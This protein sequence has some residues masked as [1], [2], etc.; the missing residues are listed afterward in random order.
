MKTLKDKR[1]FFVFLFLLSVLATMLGVFFT[2][3]RYS[4][5]ISSDSGIYGGDFEYI[6]AEK[7]E[8]ESVEELIAAVE[9]GYSNITIADSVEDP[10]IITS[11][12]T[13]V[14][15]DLIL[16]LNGHEIQRNNHNPMLNIT[17]GVRMTVIDSSSAQTGSFYNP[18]GSVLEISG[19]TLTV[20]GGDFV[21]G[22]KKSE[23]A[24]AGNGF[25]SASGGA[26]GCRHAE[27]VLPL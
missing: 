1:G 8:V 5:E 6:V 10:L 3:G 4:E 17:D 25:D 11:G 15:S 20:T 2:Q 21:S 26:L 24:N 23:Y 19:G 18:V 13:D 7:V 9:N 27:N 14:G 16:D 12:V 22:P